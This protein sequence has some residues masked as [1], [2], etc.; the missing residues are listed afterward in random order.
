MRH[1]IL[2][3]ATCALLV[4]V[5]GVAQPRKADVPGVRVEMKSA[6]GKPRPHALH[7][8]AGKCDPP[9]FES[10][11]G[12]F[13]PAGRKHGYRNPDGPHPGDL[14]NL[15]VPLGGRLTVEVLAREVSLG[16]ARGRA[17]GSRTA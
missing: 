14:P 17:T 6:D 4:P 7:I 16:G 2:I 13:N 10:A 5:A 1:T 11:G 9:G 15:H 12:H 3:A 8:H